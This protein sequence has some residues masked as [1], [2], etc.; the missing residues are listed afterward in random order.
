MKKIIL[1]SLV[2]LGVLKCAYANTP[3][4]AQEKNIFIVKEMLSQFFGKLDL[5]KMD[6]Y[7]TKNFEIELNGKKYNHKEFKDLEAT[8]FSST[9]SASTKYKDIFAS[10]NKVVGRVCFTTV[11]KGGKKEQYQDIFI[12]LIKGD[13][14]SR[15]WEIYTKHPTN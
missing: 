7:F 11:N 12:A 15:I 9:K 10:S 4:S 14:I 13:K 5:S 6:T 2:L 3:L 1:F 8:F